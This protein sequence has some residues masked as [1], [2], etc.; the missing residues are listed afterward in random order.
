MNKTIYLAGGCFWG[1]EHLFSS[2]NGI[3]NTTV[4]YANGSNVKTIDYNTVKTGTTGFKETV[5]IEYDDS[6]ID[7]EFILLAYFYVIHPEQKDRQ[8]N[9]IGSQYQT[10]IYYIDEVTKEIVDKIYEIEKTSYK[11]FYVEKEELRNF[12]PAEEYH[13]NYLEKNPNGYCH[14][15]FND[16]NIFKNI[17]FNKSEYTKCSKDI[18]KEK[19][20]Q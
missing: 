4:G 1:L 18:I 13:Q 14:I 11:E 12:I 10:G 2:L 20:S 9:D 19:S 17:T 15:S 16:M 5:K 6:I 7:L 8:A 3:K